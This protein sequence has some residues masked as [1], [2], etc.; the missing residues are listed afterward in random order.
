[1]K[2]LYDPQIFTIQKFG[3]I[4][5][6][7]VEL[8]EGMVKKGEDVTL[9]LH[10]TCNS[11]LKNSKCIQEYLHKRIFNG[12]HKDSS[13]RSIQYELKRKI[14][15]KLKNYGIPDS[16][17]RVYINALKNGTYDLVHP[18]YYDPYFY[19]YIG[20]LPYVLTVYDMINEKFPDYFANDSTILKKKYL[21][22]RASIIIAISES[23]KNDIVD[24]LGI[25]EERIQVIHLASSLK[26]YEDKI[27]L[28]LPQKYLLYTGLRNYYKNFKLFV[29]AVTPLLIEMKMHLVCTGI[30]FTKSEMSYLEDFHIS[31]RIINICA[32]DSELAML[33]TNAAA[34]VFPSVYEGFGIPILEAFNC[35]CPAIVSNINC[36]KEVA[37][38]AAEYFDPFDKVSMYNA[39]AKVIE[40]PDHRQKLISRGYKRGALFSWKKVVE[41]TEKVYK[42]VL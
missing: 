34:F 27:T 17:Q 41:E 40:C 25:P 39:I 14:E 35:G 12:K 16:N 7:F 29:E 11:Y 37:S 8:I 10:S 20:K 4:S 23:T 42:S 3:G 26:K 28:K 24:I 32:S 5:R 1:M 9:P 22:E 36:F 38:D 6:Y 13:I 19:R 33:Y 31:D 30:K 2:I 18:T 21:A 15:D